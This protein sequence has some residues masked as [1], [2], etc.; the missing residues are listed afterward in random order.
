MHTRD[1]P[2]CTLGLSMRLKKRRLPKSWERG[3]EGLDAIGTPGV[4]REDLESQR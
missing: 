3:H 4:H 2:A 1:Q